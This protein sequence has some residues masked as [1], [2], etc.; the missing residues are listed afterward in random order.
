MRRA[1]PA[2]VGWSLFTVAAGAILAFAI[3]AS[4][5]GV[6]LQAIGVVLMVVG[7]VGFATTLYLDH[8]GRDAG[9]YDDG[10]GGGNPAQGYPGP[11]YN[12]QGQPTQAYDDGTQRRWQ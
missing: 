11:G 7:V 9:G 1:T 6:S 3:T 10:Y 12:A 2:G 4:T 5:P 8:R